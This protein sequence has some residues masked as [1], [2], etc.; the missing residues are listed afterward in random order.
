MNTSENQISSS[1][2]IYSSLLKGSRER[3]QTIVLPS[4]L[5]NPLSL[6]HILQRRVCFFCTQLQELVE[7]ELENNHGN[8]ERDQLILLIENSIME[9]DQMKDKVLRKKCIVELQR[10]QVAL[11]QQ[12]EY[13]QDLLLISNWITKQHKE[14][15]KPIEL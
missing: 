5:E 8:K 4:I 15:N 11:D 9:A 12:K 2:P 14:L 10:L 3:K 7:Y 1:P 13:E 6:L